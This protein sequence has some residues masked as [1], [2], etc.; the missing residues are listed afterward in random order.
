KNLQAVLNDVRSRVED[1]QTLS[2]AMARNPKAFDELSV[3]I[4]R[5]GGEG[6]FLEDALDRVAMFAEQQGE[7]KSRVVGALAYP[8]VLLGIGS[9][10]VVGLMIFVVPS[11]EELFANLAQQGELPAVTRG[12]LAFS[13]FI[14]SIYGLALGCVLVAGVLMLKQYWSTDEGRTS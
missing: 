6:G 8:M 7:L 13:D 3:S 14:G 1:G 12:L 5:A 4:I 11:F 9:L 10:I 2:D